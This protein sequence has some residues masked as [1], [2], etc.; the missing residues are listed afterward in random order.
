MNYWLELG[1]VR[2]RVRFGRE[3]GGKGLKISKCVSALLSHNSIKTLL[4][5]TRPYVTMHSTASTEL[6]ELLSL[7]SRHYLGMSFIFKAFFRIHEHSPE[8]DFPPDYD[9]VWFMTN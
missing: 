4:Q 5:I 8:K 9:I 3:Q 2:V 6:S 1:G 7:V